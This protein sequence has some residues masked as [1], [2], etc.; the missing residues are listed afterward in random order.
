MEVL[1]IELACAV[2]NVFYYDYNDHDGDYDVYDNDY[3]LHHGDYD[4]S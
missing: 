1:I 4:D 2:V 3:D